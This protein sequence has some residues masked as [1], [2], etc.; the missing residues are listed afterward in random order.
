MFKSPVLCVFYYF[1]LGKAAS[2]LFTILYCSKLVLM[3]GG[4]SLLFA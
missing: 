1:M 2:H 4:K 3:L